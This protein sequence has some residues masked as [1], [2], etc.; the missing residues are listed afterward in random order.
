MERLVYDMKKEYNYLLVREKAAEKYLN[1]DTRPLKE[2][3][4]W[5]PEYTKILNRLN[6]L[7]EEVGYYRRENILNGFP[8]PETERPV[9]K[10]SA[11]K[12]TVNPPEVEHELQEMFKGEKLGQRA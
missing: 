9:R 10:P 12:G 2:R 5:T 4:E 3:E 7:L 1:D 6:E 11:G 8:G